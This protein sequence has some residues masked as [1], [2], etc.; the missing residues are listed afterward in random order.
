MAERG[1]KVALVARSTDKLDQLAKDLPYALAMPADMAKE[2]EIKKMAAKVKDH[3]GR[4]DILINNAGQ[5]Y[6]ALVEKTWLDIFR[7]LFELDVIGPLVAMQAV[8]PIMKAQGVGM[9]I[10][11]TSSDV[12]LMF[13]PNMSAYSALKRALVGISLTAREEAVFFIINLLDYFFDFN[14][15]L[16][17]ASVLYLVL[18]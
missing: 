7:Q 5:G 9:I 12:A 13:L 6:D 17:Y 10:N 2:D 18:I 16:V 3:Y 11:I 1:A 4:I 8:I 15:T 14:K